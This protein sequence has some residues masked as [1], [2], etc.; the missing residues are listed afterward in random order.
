MIQQLFTIIRHTFLESIRQ[1][2]FVVLILIAALALV[3]NPSLA[4]YTLDDDNKLLIDMG[5]STLFLAGLLMA[6]F[7][8]TAVLSNELENRTALTVVSKPVQ[9]PVFILGKYL[10]VSAAIAVAYWALCVIF[11]LTVRH[12][13]MQTAATPFDGPVLV[14]GLGAAAIALAGATLGNYFYQTAFTSSFVLGLSALMTGA[15]VLV[16]MIDKQWMFQSPMVDLSPQLMVGLLL[17]L[18]AVLILT[19]VAIAAS[20]RLGQLMTLTACVLVFV[21]GLIS[22]YLSSRLST[23]Y[24][25]LYWIT[26]NLQLFWPADA[27]TQG[28]RF[29]GG[30]VGLVTGYTAL[31]VAAMM[32]LAVSLF[33]QRELM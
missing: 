14:F 16:L 11:L 4:A 13:V 22:D 3:L 5:L 2:I 9:R 8:A 28:H 26:P 32:G 18:E 23:P 7:T 12:R 20:T 31:Y 29:T 33:Q 21:L 15:W 30:Y 24:M 6:A 19:A 17:V 1:P 10:G 25:P 27:M